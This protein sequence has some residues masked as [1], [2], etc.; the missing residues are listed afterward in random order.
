MGDFLYMSGGG[1]GIVACGGLEQFYCASWGC[2]ASVAG[3]GEWKVSKEDLITVAGQGSNSDV[4]LRFTNLGK[5]EKGWEAEKSPGLLLYIIGRNNLGLIFTI[6]LLIK[7]RG[8][9]LPVAVGPNWILTNPKP[10]PRD[11]VP[12]K[13]APKLVLR[14]VT[15]ACPQVLPPQ[16]SPALG[17][18]S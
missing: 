8:N 1:C 17:S 11:L 9:P 5:Q 15:A 18:F 16:G 4:L 3:N 12:K 13:P 7:P 6:R 2:G 14:L 10:L